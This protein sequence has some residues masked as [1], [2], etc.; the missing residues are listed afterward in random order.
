MQQ[1]IVALAHLGSP[2]SPDYQVAAEET[3][4]AARRLSPSICH[5]EDSTDDLPTDMHGVAPAVVE[6]ASEI[7][8]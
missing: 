6:I 1:E 2:R 5:F 8:R 7:W 4:Q 3:V